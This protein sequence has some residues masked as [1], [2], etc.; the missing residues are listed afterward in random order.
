MSTNDIN[1]NGAFQKYTLGLGLQTAF[2]TWLTPGVR[3]AAYVNSNGAAD[4]DDRQTLDNTVSTL[5][6]GLARCRAGRGDIVLVD[7]RHSESIA[8]ADAMSNLVAGTRIIGLGFGNLRPTFTWTAAGATFL[9][10]QANCVLENLVLT[11]ASSANSGVTV[12][13]PITVSAAGCG[14]VGCRI[15]FGDDANDI[16]T[17]GITTTAA[18]DQFLFANNDCVGATAAECTT[19]L[20]I[21]GV[22]GLKMFNNRIVGASSSTTVGLIRFLTTASTNIQVDGLWVRNNKALSTIAITGMAAVTGEA[23]NVF[24]TVLSNDVAA[25]TG[26]W[27]T[28]A[29]MVLGRNVVVVNVIAERAALFGTESA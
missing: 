2:G 10:D 8:T 26:A 29:S 21:V 11:L 20:Q 18:A 15:N 3:V 6:A 4:L 23:D 7:P 13:A 19:F 22:E 14:I 27:A 24:M 25:L 5:N 16:V 1:I 12:A 17:I 28:L 9:L